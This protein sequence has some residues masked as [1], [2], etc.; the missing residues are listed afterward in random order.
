MKNQWHLLNDLRSH[1]NFS[2][3]DKNPP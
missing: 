2:E 3:E 1:P